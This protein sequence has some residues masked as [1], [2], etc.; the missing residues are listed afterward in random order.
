MPAC[1]LKSSRWSRFLCAAF[2]VASWTVNPALLRWLPLPVGRLVLKVLPHPPDC[3]LLKSGVTCFSSRFL[4]FVEPGWAR[5][6]QLA[7]EVIA[8]NLLFKQLAL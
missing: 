6:T 8:Q 4:W 7:S 1:S 5:G 3:E 2:P